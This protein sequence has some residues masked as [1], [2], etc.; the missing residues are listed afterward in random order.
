MHVHLPDAAAASKLQAAELRL[1][2]LLQAN[3]CKQTATQ[4][5]WCLPTPRPQVLAWPFFART[6]SRFSSSTL[7]LS[8]RLT[9]SPS[10]SLLV[11]SSLGV[12]LAC[13]SADA[14][15]PSA[16]ALSAA[17]ILLKS[18]RRQ[19]RRGAYFLTQSGGTCR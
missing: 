16:A 8:C 1:I 11:F 7:T 15:L 18:M 14:R 4:Q 10:R 19:R 17:D 2:S 9:N 3:R 12:R 5:S 13:C 6:G